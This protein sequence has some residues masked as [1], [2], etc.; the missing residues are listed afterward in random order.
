MAA[1]KNPGAILLVSC[2]ELGHQPLSVASPAAVLRRAGFVPA[3][4]DLSQQ[5]LDPALVKRARLVA[6]AVPMHTALRLGVR[7][8]A[9][10]REMNPTA[11]IAFYGL[12]ASLNAGALLSASDG[13]PGASAVIGGEY[14]EPLL[15]L[16]EAVDHAS[17]PGDLRATLRAAGP[18]PGVRTASHPTAPWIA[19]VQHE[20]PDRS[21]LPPL[22]GY[23]QVEED[24]VRRA[25]GQVEASRGCLHHCRHCPIPPVYGGRFFV[26]PREIVLED[27]RRQVEAGATHFTFGDPDFLNGPGH[28]MAVARALHAA[29]PAVT[30]DVTAKVEHLLKHRD[31]LGELRRLGCLFAVT[32]A[33]SLSDR[34]L[35][36]LDKGH[37][38]AD[39]EAVIA[40]ARGAGLPLR[41]TWVP[42]TP[43]S[44]LDDYL[45]LLEFAASWNLV[46][47]IDPVQWS[48]RLLVPPGSLLEA[49]EEFL[50][51]RGELDAARFTWLWEH[52]DPRVDELQRGVAALVEAAAVADEDPRATYAAVV[53]ATARAGVA[54]RGGRVGAVVAT[55]APPAVALGKGR[56]PRL[57]EPWF[58]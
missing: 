8:A 28:T 23:V 57:T 19:R 3:A 12:Y 5:P 55:D 25:A 10:I 37:T 18:I 52:P 15:R 24:G 42:F 9:R 35:G 58:C 43:W 54:G 50:P 56:T 17:G 51:V 32:A 16:A 22:T 36:I 2:Y 26:V 11:A 29:F 6:I 45:E 13:G 49:H 4:L 1:L 47:S 31:L 39:I 40:L 33:E 38:R 20:V 41:P 7:A 21:V 30:F 48:I 53:R 14:E 27:I 46:D 34:V 44:G